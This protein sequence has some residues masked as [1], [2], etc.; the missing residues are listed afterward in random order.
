MRAAQPTQLASTSSSMAHTPQLCTPP[1]HSGMHRGV[2][3]TYGGVQIPKTHSKTCACVSNNT[4]A[5]MRVAVPCRPH[6][7]N[8]VRMSPVRVQI[9]THV[10]WHLTSWSN[11]S[12][13]VQLLMSTPHTHTQM[14]LTC[15]ASASTSSSNGQHSADA[16]P[17]RVV[18]TGLG[19][20]S[21]LGNDHE[22]FYARLLAGHSGISMIEN[23]D[24]GGRVWQGR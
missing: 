23:W 2:C 3:S 4:G 8:R 22:S 17:R 5:S 12:C 9:T 19:V 15:Q 13:R 7:I 24:A 1:F 16:S 14:D 10:I 21:C 11:M 18:V 6:R 20:V